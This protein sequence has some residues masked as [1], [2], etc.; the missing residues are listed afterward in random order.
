[1]TRGPRLSAQTVSVLDELLRSPTRWRYGYDLMKA[2]GISAGTLYPILARLVDAGWLEAEW[3]TPG[4]D[5]RPARHHYRLTATGRA[6]ARE[7]S[8][9][10]AAAYVGLRRRST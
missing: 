1:M 10:A 8:G 4:E 6:G 2:T 3:E 9:R 5:G 7:M